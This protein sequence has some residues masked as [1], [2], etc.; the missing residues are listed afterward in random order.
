MDARGL[1]DTPVVTQLVETVN[2]LIESIR[3]QSQIALPQPDATQMEDLRTEFPQLAGLLDGSLANSELGGLPAM[4]L[5]ALAR[6]PDQGDILAPLDYLATKE[7]DD[8]GPEQG[9]AEATEYADSAVELREGESLADGL[10]RAA[11]ILGQPPQSTPSEPSEQAGGRNASGL[12]TRLLAVLNLREA[13]LDLPDRVE[14][15][16]VVPDESFTSPPAPAEP[17]RELEQLLPEPALLYAKVTEVYDEDYSTWTDYDTSGWIATVEASPCAHSD[18]TGANTDVTLVLKATEVDDS[19]S[20]GFADI[21][22][23]DVIAY[24]PCDGKEATADADVFYDGVVVLHGA[25][26]GAVL[27][28]NASGDDPAD[29]R[30]AVGSLTARQTEWNRN[31]TVKEGVLIRRSRWSYD[32]TNHE[33]YLLNWEELYDSA[34]CLLTVS[35]ETKTKFADVDPC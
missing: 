17:A 33:I 32:S 9:Q 4:E 2:A 13:V 25:A 19:P 27:S 20:L 24:L 3:A 22:A 14:L 18:G 5:S 28:T 12:L 29:L 26:D 15:E 8:P 16:P 11:Q 31:D 23:D 7:P 10:S 1:D 6:Q 30:A 21:A 34:G 35:K